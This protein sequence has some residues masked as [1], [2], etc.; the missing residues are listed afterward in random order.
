M[1][2]F[3]LT[4]LFLIATTSIYTYKLKGFCYEPIA[5]QIGNLNQYNIITENSLFN[6]V[7]DEQAKIP[8][9]FIEFFSFDKSDFH[10]N[11]ESERFLIESEKYLNQNGHAKL[12]ITGHTN[13]TGSRRYNQ[14]LGY[15]RAQSLQKYFISKGIPASKILIESKGEN[16]PVSENN[17]QIGRILNRRT[18]IT[19]KI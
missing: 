2:V 6:L 14:A 16:E 9:V 17:T 12:I 11:S 18:Y 10:S 7:T 5:I 4:L 13:A 3:I 15:R 19:I 1:K 8:T